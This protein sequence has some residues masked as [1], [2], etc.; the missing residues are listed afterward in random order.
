MSDLKSWNELY[1]ATKQNIKSRRMTGNL[2][3]VTEV[4]FATIN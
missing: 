1:E 2:L 4:R 3:T